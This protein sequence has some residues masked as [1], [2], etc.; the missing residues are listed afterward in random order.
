MWLTLCFCWAAVLGGEAPGRGSGSVMRTQ[1][2]EE[3][4]AGSRGTACGKPAGP[5]P[6]VQ[7]DTN[8]LTAGPENKVRMPLRSAPCYEL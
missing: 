6:S 8:S 7:C 2:L 4:E 3:M 1:D 5:C